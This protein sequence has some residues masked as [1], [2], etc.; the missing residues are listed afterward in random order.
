MYADHFSL[1]NI[2]FGIASGVSHPEKSVVT[3]FENDVIFLAV[4]AKAGFLPELTQETRKT[5]SENTI[6]A[7]A[8]LPKSEHRAA[9][10]AIQKLLAN[11]AD[12]LPQH[13]RVPMSDV[14][15][16]LPIFINNFTDFSCSRDHVLNA[17]E[18]VFGK[19]E[20]PPGFDHFPVGYTA[21]ASSIVVSGTG[22]RRPMGQFRDGHKVVFGGTKKLDYELEV[23]CVIGKGSNLGEPVNI[24]NADDHIFGLVLL[25][26]W[27]ARDIQS[28]EMNPLGPLNGKSFATTISPWVITLDA[29]AP[30][31][32]P[33]PPR[34]PK[35]EIATY[36]KDPEPNSTY[37]IE[38]SAS[39]GNATIADEICKS[40]FS[41]LYW[42]LRDLVAQQTANGCNLVT[43]DI[44]ATGTISGSIDESHGCLMEHAGRG[45][46][47]I[48][49]ETGGSIKKTWLEDG[50]TVRLTGIAGPGVG[51]GDCVGTILSHH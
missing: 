49:T 18:A 5:F 37:D 28:L 2:P 20:L 3:R 43:G 26:D 51:F 27:S 32:A 41:N 14:N 12:D 19:R 48:K 50:D 44:L 6:N 39:I 7:F 4:L 25:N 13:A 46:V 35:I 17:S 33:Q 24:K 1:E 23:A 47:E 11:F 36:L 8:A 9:R 22:V 16:H 10:S 42:T 30:F 40:N 45:G 34:N 38:L 21:R 15:V 31:K 29:L